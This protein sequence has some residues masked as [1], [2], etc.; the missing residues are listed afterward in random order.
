MFSLIFFFLLVNDDKRANF[1]T[2]TEVREFYIWAR[3]NKKTK[4]MVHSSIE[5][6][7]FFFQPQKCYLWETPLQSQKHIKILFST[8]PPPPRSYGVLIRYYLPVMTHCVWWFVK[9]LAVCHH[10]LQHWLVS[11]QQS[12]GAACNHMLLWLLTDCCPWSSC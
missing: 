3:N 7:S 10:Q 9:L 1:Y 6:F 2:R 11:S 5:S 8:P 4:K 12:M